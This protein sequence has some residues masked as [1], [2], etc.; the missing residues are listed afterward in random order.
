[1]TNPK[2]PASVTFAPAESYRGERVE[3]RVELKR[4]ESLD[5]AIEWIE[6]AMPRWYGGD[7]VD[8]LQDALDVLRA[9]R[10]RRRTD[11]DRP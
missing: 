3:M 10:E 6:D 2:R 9:E 7:L 1:M 4:P 11:A 8:S 5:R